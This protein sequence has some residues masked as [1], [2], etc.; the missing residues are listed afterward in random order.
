MDRASALGIGLGS[1]ACDGI[2][3]ESLFPLASLLSSV[4]SLSSAQM[5][6]NKCLTFDSIASDDDDDVSHDD[7]D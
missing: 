6:V 1:S 2:E 7:G 3:E 4:S 5:S